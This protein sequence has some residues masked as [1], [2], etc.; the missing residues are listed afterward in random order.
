MTRKTKQKTNLFEKRH[1]DIK[2]MSHIVYHFENCLDAGL[3]P[4][5]TPELGD[6]LKKLVDQGIIPLSTL[7]VFLG[8]APFAI[9]YWN[10]IKAIYK[11]LETRL[12]E[13]SELKRHSYKH[14]FEISLIVRNLALLF[15]RLETPMDCSKCPGYFRQSKKQPTFCNNPCEHW[16][17]GI[18]LTRQ[19]LEYDGHTFD[20]K[21]FTDQ[22]IKVDGIH[23][24]EIFIETKNSEDK[25][26]LLLLVDEFMDRKELTN[27]IKL[28]QKFNEGDSAQN[29]PKIQ[30][31]RFFNSNEFKHPW[32][33]RGASNNGPQAHFFSQVTNEVYADIKPLTDNARP[34]KKTIQYMRR[35]SRRLLRSLQQTNTKIYIDLCIAF[36]AHLDYPQKNK[37]SSQWL[38]HEIIFGTDMS[39]QQSQNGRGKIEYPKDYGQ[40]AQRSEPCQTEWDKAIEKIKPLI[41]KGS[42]Y[43]IVTEFCLKIWSD[44][45][46][47][48]RKVWL[49]LSINCLNNYLQSSSKVIAQ[50]ALE[51]LE[52]EPEKIN[53]LEPASMAR[54]LATVETEMAEYYFNLFF[55]NHKEL[56]N[57]MWMTRFSY[58]FDDAICSIKSHANT[59]DE[60]E[61]CLV[62]GLLSLQLPWNGY[63]NIKVDNFQKKDQFQLPKEIIKKIKNPLRWNSKLRPS[64]WRNGKWKRP[65]VSQSDRGLMGWPHSI[66]DKDLVTMDSVPRIRL[67][68][69]LLNANPHRLINLL[70]LK[71]HLLLCHGAPISIMEIEDDLLTRK[72][73]LEK[74]RYEIFETQTRNSIRTNAAEDISLAIATEETGHYTQ[75]DLRID[76]CEVCGSSY[77]NH[78]PFIPFSERESKAMTD[79]KRKWG[80]GPHVQSKRIKTAFWEKVG[81]HEQKFKVLDPAKWL[82]TEVLIS[83][84]RRMNNEELEPAIIGKIYKNTAKAINNGNDEIVLRLLKEDITSIPVRTII[85]RVI[86]VDES[87]W[88]NKYKN[89]KIFK[90]MLSESSESIPYLWK[91]LG[92]KSI[93][94][95]E[96]LNQRFFQNSELS[97]LI[98]K[99]FIPEFIENLSDEQASF[100]S[101]C[102]DFRPEL[103]NLEDGLLMQACLTSHSV[104]NEKALETVKEIGITT[105]FAIGLIESDFPKAE[106]VAKEYFLA[107][108]PASDGYI[109]DVLSL[110]DSPHERTRYFGLELIERN[111][112]IIQM[113]QLLLRLKENRHKNIMKFLANE[114]VEYSAVAPDSLD[115]DIH[116]LRS[117]NSERDAKELVKR[118]LEKTIPNYQQSK[119]KDLIKALRELSLGLVPAD[120]EWAIEQLTKLKLRG[121]E[122]PEIKVEKIE[123]TTNEVSTIL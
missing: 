49:G 33:S 101:S 31:I 11:L 111:K 9:N 39:V 42:S 110:C 94:E 53:A 99:N 69:Y 86:S 35:R 13:L 22:F 106:D 4:L 77:R 107:L 54:G 121:Q 61:R 26:S 20:K 56:I 73:V 65:N 100:L 30:T 47:E 28:A 51:Q 43:L 119:L 123:E 52:L 122:I 18:K 80:R 40:R 25:I 92:Y 115:F 23:A 82:Q 38:L 117:R 91:R 72:S 66:F 8:H 36:F 70:S 60:K 87:L 1:D 89:G 71:T 109:D 62:L 50:F 108:D 118:R 116:I 5:I 2:C 17:G 78:A 67:D 105:F 55:Q 68:H 84:N 102:I 114:M 79:Y 90:K 81:E 45:S 113:P 34:S 10:N 58:D 12:I 97:S 63:I 59:D 57:S 14:K 7:T 41:I 104:I 83:L 88:V 44:Q 16:S 74:K 103:F 29:F 21:E 76:P 120:K 96:L 6:E 15:S 98:I 24:A 85:S 112:N 48:K 75:A 32:T 93:E 64:T 46:D 27:F 37:M 19:M 95:R 3:T